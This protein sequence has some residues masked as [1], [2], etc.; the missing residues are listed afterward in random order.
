MFPF[1]LI[2]CAWFLQNRWQWRGCFK[3]NT[4]K[5]GKARSIC[6]TRRMLLKCISS[7]L[8]NQFP[9]KLFAYGCNNCVE[10]LGPRLNIKIVFL[11]M[12]IPML[13][14]RRS[15]DR[16]IF[17]MGVPMLVGHILYWD[18]P[19]V[20]IVDSSLNKP[21]HSNDVLVFVLFYIGAWLP[22]SAQHNQPTLNKVEKKY[23]SLQNALTWVWSIGKHSIDSLW[24]L[25]DTLC[26]IYLHTPGNIERDLIHTNSTW[27]DM[28]C[29]CMIN[30]ARRLLSTTALDSS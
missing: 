25:P 27:W 7:M 29:C 19:L 22:C 3:I 24:P 10:Y 9:S 30:N 6:L 1:D 12:G 2:S 11:G 28:D 4:A 5:H 13:K 20:V 23:K 26:K 14:I 18:S 15:R 21:S 16:L 17:N 8:H